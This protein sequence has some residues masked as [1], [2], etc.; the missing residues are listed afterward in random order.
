LELKLEPRMQL[1][2]EKTMI[3]RSV[4]HVYTKGNFVEPTNL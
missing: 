3:K 4:I 2:E 1:H